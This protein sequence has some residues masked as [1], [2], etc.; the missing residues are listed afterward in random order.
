MKRTKRLLSLLSAAA[1]SLS[2]FT[3]TAA[4]ENDTKRSVAEIVA[5][6]TTQQK[7]EQMI[8]PT[9]RQ[10]YDGVNDPYSDHLSDEQEKFFQGA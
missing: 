9:V 10:W 2:M 5:G 6:M 4:A 1:M 8:M 3:V 7:I